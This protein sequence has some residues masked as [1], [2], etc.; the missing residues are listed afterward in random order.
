MENPKLNIIFS[1]KRGTSGKISGNPL[2]NI[3]MNKNDMNP[4]RFIKKRKKIQS[5]KNPPHAE[6]KCG[7][8]FLMNNNNNH[9]LNQPQNNESNKHID[10]I[11]QTNQNNQLTKPNQMKNQSNKHID[12]ILQTN[13]INHLMK[14]NLTKNQSNKHTDK[15]NQINYNNGSKQSNQMYI[16]NKQHSNYII[17]SSQINPIN[18]LTQSNHMNNQKN[19]MI[20]SGQV[21]YLIQHDKSNHPINQGY[22][23]NKQNQ[24]NQNKPIKITNN[25]NIIIKINKTSSKN[26]YQINQAQVQARPSTKD[27]NKKQDNHKENV[28]K[29]SEKSVSNQSTEVTR[30]KNNNKVAKNVNNNNIKDINNNKEDNKEKFKSDISRNNNVTPNKIIYPQKKIEKYV[31]L[32]CEGNSSFIISG[33]YCLANNEKIKE[34]LFKAYTGTSLKEVGITLFFWRILLHLKEKDKE[35]YKITKFY[36]NIINANKALET[37][38]NAVDFIVFILDKFH[39]DNKKFKNINQEIELKEDIYNNITQYK[40]YL[41]MYENTYIFNNFAWINQKI[42]KCLSCKQ[43]TKTYTYYFTYDLNI[44]SALNKC[45]INSKLGKKPTNKPVLCL[46]KCFEYSLE[47]EMLFNV[48]CPSCDKK[49]HLE[50]C[51]KIYS[52]S[53]YLIILFS[54]FTQEDN[55]RSIR[56]NNVNI[57]IEETI[58]IK[59]FDNSTIEYKINSIIY[60]NLSNNRYITYY[61]ENNLW[62]KHDIDIK[63]E[64]SNN[65]LKVFNIDIIPIIIFYESSIKKI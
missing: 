6:L 47:K 51:S 48:Y 64:S 43:E 32:I 55:I 65:F 13:Q 42:V 33:L 61:F 2:L 46:S 26:V 25:Q 28:T 35:V 60:Y 39:K 54:G 50:R 7:G 18:G 21:K 4:E 30:K 3:E 58:K 45:I 23:K 36:Q 56:E 24:L 1:Y 20:K 10:K 9:H 34:Y 19:H 62:I 17:K 22:Q 40:K 14:P 63:V 12:K 38:N 8:Q 57:E 5:V 16:I 29:K 49:T 53:N 44:S 15:F 27:N 52:L 11:L 31:N 37:S 41:N 59:K